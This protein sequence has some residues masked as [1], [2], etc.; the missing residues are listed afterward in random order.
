MGLQ[1]HDIV[2]QVMPVLGHLD[3]DNF[4]DHSSRNLDFACEASVARGSEYRNVKFTE[5]DRVYLS[6][7][8]VSN[9]QLPPGLAKQGK[10]PPGHA[11][12]M[13]AA[14]YTV[15]PGACTAELSAIPQGWSRVVAD[16]RVILL[17]TA[18]REIDS[19]FWRAEPEGE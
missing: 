7:C 16:A 15:I 4:S 13:A 1:R 8:L 6:R 10:I 11:K 3:T 19:F 9:Y 14:G 2:G 12:K 17:D 18:H 5:H